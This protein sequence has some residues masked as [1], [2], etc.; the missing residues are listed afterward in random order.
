MT[1]KRVNG[2]ELQYE[3]TEAENES[4]IPR[5]LDSFIY[6]NHL[7]SGVSFRVRLPVNEL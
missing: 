1:N 2:N 5:G 7:S 6:S 3:Q 4:V